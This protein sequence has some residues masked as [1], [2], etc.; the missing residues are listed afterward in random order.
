MNW[1]RLLHVFRAYAAN[2]EPEP[3]PPLP[4]YT[5]GEKSVYL[6]LPSEGGDVS[7]TA[8]LTRWGCQIN[9]DVDRYGRAL[10]VEV[11][12]VSDVVVDGDQLA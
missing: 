9:I 8:Q 4:E 7:L 1:R 5:P 3:L 2:E 12:N 6:S 10:G 11:L